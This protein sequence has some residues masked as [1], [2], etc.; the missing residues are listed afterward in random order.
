MLEC[1]NQADDPDLSADVD[2][3]IRAAAEAAPGG[4]GEGGGGGAGG[5]PG[6]GAWVRLCADA[7]LVRRGLSAEFAAAKRAKLLK[8][9]GVGAQAPAKKR[10]AAA[11]AAAAQAAALREAEA[12]GGDGDGDDAEVVPV[13]GWLRWA[14]LRLLAEA[15][16]AEGGKPRSAFTRHEERVLDPRML[17]RERREKREREREERE[18][19]R[20]KKRGRKT[21]TQYST[22]AGFM[23]LVVL[24]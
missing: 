10:A 3:E 1:K 5:W 16:K 21:H 7:A 9:A 2:L 23:S 20:R 13:G 19:E 8:G 24:V 22:H 15:G 17:V 4:S 14:R 18:R 6:V 11:A 12:G